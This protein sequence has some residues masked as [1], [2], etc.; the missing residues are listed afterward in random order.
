AWL[1]RARGG[2]SPLHPRPAG[3]ADALRRHRE[4]MT[5]GGPRIAGWLPGLLLAAGLVTPCGA[6][7]PVIPGETPASVTLNL[8]P[9]HWVMDAVRRAEGMGLLE[10]S[11][12]FRAA[13]SLDHAAEILEEAAATASQRD[14]AT[15][16]LA[17]GWLSRF[18]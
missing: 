6:Q 5:A 13:L 15:A 11:V 17:R 7:A 9:D 12:P 2:G 1:A 16:R 8:L 3:G 18:R 10:Q 14:S 4:R